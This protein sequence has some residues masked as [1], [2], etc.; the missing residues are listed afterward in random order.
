M[1]E[2][3]CKDLSSNVIHQVM[4]SMKTCTLQNPHG[5][6]KC[7]SWIPWNLSFHYII[8][9]I[10]LQTMLWHHNAR[11]NSHQRWKQTRN[12]VC[13]HL[14]CELTSTMNVTEWQVSWIL[15]YS[16]CTMRGPRRHTSWWITYGLVDGLNNVHTCASSLSPTYDQPPVSLINSWFQ[17]WNYFFYFKFCLFSISLHE[18][19]TKTG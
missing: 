6:L 7:C 15:W 4:C 8:Y 12:R 5:F 11:V 2:M 10:R 9:F 3:S 16:W 17:L 1:T 13:F 14:W 19:V 18:C